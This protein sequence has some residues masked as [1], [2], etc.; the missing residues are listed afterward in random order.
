MK[1]ARWHQVTPYRIEFR[2][3]GGWLSVFGLP[4]LAA[5]IFMWLSLAGVIPAKGLDSSTVTWIVMPLAALAFT[6][7]GTTLV[8]G[9]VWTAI[10]RAEGTLEHQWGLLVA[11]HTTTTRLGD[12]VAIVIGF[13]AGDSDSA[14]SFPLMLK[15]RGSESRKIA[16][17]GSYADA[18]EC[19]ELIATLLNVD[20]EDATSDHAVSVP[21]S[22]SSLPLSERLRLDGS[23]Q[24]SLLRPSNLRSD[25][26]SEANGVRITI[27]AAP[28][29]PF[30]IVATLVPVAIIIAVFGPMVGLFWKKASDPFG[31]IFFG[32][33]TFL[34]AAI[35]GMTLVNAIVRARRGA[36]M[37]TASTDGIRIEERGAWR[38]TTKGVYAAA[39][40]FD[41]DYSTTES[42]MASAHRT[43]VAI[44][45]EA[46]GMARPT[47]MSPGVE[48]ALTRLVAFARSKGITLKTRQGLVSVGAGLEDG[49]VRYLHALIRRALVGSPR[50]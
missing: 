34:F 24:D 41:V 10:D 50:L 36:T 12:C 33:V 22:R 38:T 3:G 13:N 44:A 20:V 2:Q 8:L 47:A 35:P 42:M 49:E 11:M 28:V 45:R 7:V 43:A 6:A 15:S 26:R 30:M 37:V 48:R 14:D 16:S 5:G 18:R 25:V 1:A 23:G 29:H 4:F 31:L 40:I 9:R 19:A 27:P 17:V 46:D 32:F 39:D 21:A